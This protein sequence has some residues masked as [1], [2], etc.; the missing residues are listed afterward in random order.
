M[1]T[2]HWYRY[3]NSITGVG[4]QNLPFDVDPN[5][6]A[7]GRTPPLGPPGGTVLRVFAD[8]KFA[9]LTASGTP[10]GT[11]WWFGQFDLSAAVMVLDTPT[12][13]IGTIFDAI[14]P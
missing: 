13:N 7:V 12:E 14:D 8:F 1:A 5:T 9:A 3:F 11:P 10:S 4:S 2:R 6:F